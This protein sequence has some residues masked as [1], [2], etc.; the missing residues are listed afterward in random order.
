MPPEN[1]RR[2]RPRGAAGPVMTG[3]TAEDKR[4]H[5]EKELL[6]TPIAELGLPV[7]VVNTLEDNNILLFGQLLAK[8]YEQLMKMANFGETTLAEVRRL[9]R[10]TGLAV[11]QWK[12]PRKPKSKPRPKPRGKKDPFS[13]W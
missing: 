3:W 4:A 7:R 6:A 11:P 12:K 8:T 9:A 1:R 13:I 10:E 2:R 5:R